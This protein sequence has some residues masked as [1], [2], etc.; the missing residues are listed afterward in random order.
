MA[1]IPKTINIKIEGLKYI[2]KTI[3]NF[4]EWIGENHYRLY[5]VE[6]NIYYWRNEDQNLKTTKQ[7]FKEFDKQRFKTIKK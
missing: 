3:L 4:P 7:L 5:N 6:N 1:K 2:K